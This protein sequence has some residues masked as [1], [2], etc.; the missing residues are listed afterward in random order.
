M[1][2]ER[3]HVPPGLVLRHAREC[4]VVL[5]RRRTQ[6]QLALACSYKDIYTV[7]GF[8]FVRRILKYF[9]DFRFIEFSPHTWRNVLLDVVV[10]PE[11]DVVEKSGAIVYV[12]VSIAPRD[13][14][15]WDCLKWRK[16]MRKFQPT[17]IC[18]RRNFLQVRCHTTL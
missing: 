5:D 6:E 15:L 2:R 12:G 1:Q 9:E 10:V 18:I 16:H 7:C 11:I 13:L 8:R 4:P 14:S 17:P 3:A